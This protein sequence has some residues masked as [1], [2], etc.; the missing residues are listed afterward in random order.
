MID[1]ISLAQ[2]CAPVVA[3]TTIAAIVR[4]ESGGH[5][6]ALHD[7]TTGRSFSP[8]DQR[9][10][11]SLLSSLI[12]AGHSVDAGLMQVNSR[13]YARYGLTPQ[14]AFDTCS[15]VR[16]GGLILVA[17][18]KQAVRG[19][20]ASEQAGRAGLG[21]SQ[22]ALWHAVQAY[23]SGNLHGAPQY[24]ARVWS[25]AGHVAGLP[26]HQIDITPSNAQFAMNWTPAGSW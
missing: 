19:A 24:A 10:A 17:A 22:A 18:W 4:V 23:N 7:N 11:V 25:A 21:S 9:R 15:N 26:K 13:N 3:P 16:V 8:A 1:I 20:K 2:Q 5:P 14:T 12:Q 6:L